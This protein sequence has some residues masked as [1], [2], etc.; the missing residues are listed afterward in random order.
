MGQLIYTDLSAL[1]YREIAHFSQDR[2][3]LE[4]FNTGQDIHKVMASTVYGVESNNVTKDQRRDAK[5]FNYAAVYGVG[6]K[7]FFERLGR[8]DYGLYDKIKNR[9]PGVNLWRDKVLLTL[10]KTRRIKSIFGRVWEYDKVTWDVEREAFNY[11]VQSAGHD[12]LQIYLMEVM[13]TVE[14]VKWP[15]ETPLL[16]NEK[17]DSFILDVRDIIADQ[18]CDIVKEIGKDLNPLILRYFGVKMTV[19]FI[20]EV[21]ILSNLGST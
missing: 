9:Y 19:P 10:R 7:T 4:L 21:K 1:E 2:T 8:E 14:S 3:L 5:T 18:C 6:E 20:A 15:C 12:I 11:I 16:V 13:D 17:H